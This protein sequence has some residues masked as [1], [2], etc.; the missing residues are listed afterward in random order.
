MPVSQSFRDRADSA[1]FYE[2]WV[3]AVLTR[4]GLYVTLHPFEIDGKDHGKSWDLDVF[5]EPGHLIS[6]RRKIKS[7]SKPRGSVRTEAVPV[8][9]KSLSLKFHNVDDYPFGT[10]IVCSQNNFLRKWP[11]K[12]QTQ[13]DFLL[14]STRT[15]SIVWIPKHTAVTLGHDVLDGTRN[16]LYKTVVVNKRQLC[17]FQDFIEYVKETSEKASHTIGQQSNN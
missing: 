6:D 2:A 14:V 4:A 16:E 8:E 3:G 1:A 15:G 10:V 11:G 13:R 12:Q 17:P 5:V 9:V 7:L